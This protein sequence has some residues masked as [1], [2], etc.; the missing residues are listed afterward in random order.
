MIAVTDAGTQNSF[1]NLQY[2]F[3]QLQ[4]YVRDLN[5]R[6]TEGKQEIKVAG[7]QGS[8]R[9]M[10]SGDEGGQSHGGDTDDQ[11]IKQIQKKLIQHDHDIDAMRKNLAHD[12]ITKNDLKIQLHDKVEKAEVLNMMP[13]I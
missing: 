4:I 5:L 13:D 8:H 9:R 10:V 7:K 1:E 6:V 3:T 2:S 12:F 11:T